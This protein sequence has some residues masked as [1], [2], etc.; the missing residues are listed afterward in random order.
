MSLIEKI[1][2]FIAL[3]KMFKEVGKMDKIKG[4]LGKLDGFKSVAGLLMVVAYFALPQYTSVKVPD[5]VLN[6]GTGLAGLGL[7]MKLEKGLGLLTKALDVL[8][9]V[10]NVLKAVVE[11]LKKKEEVK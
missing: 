9:R 1:K 8:G 10:I 5:M 6:M 2:M 11:A 3:N 4:L 7:S